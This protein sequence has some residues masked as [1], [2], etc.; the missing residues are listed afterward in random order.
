MNETLWAMLTVFGLGIAY[1]LAAIPTGVAMHLNPWTAALCAWAGYTAIAAA[2]LAVGTPARKWLT[3]KFGISARPDPQKL[4]WRVWIRWGLPGLA[5]IAPVTCGPYFAALI[6]LML[7]ERPWRLLLWIAL[8]VIPWC[9]F[10]VVLAETGSHLFQP[11][12]R[13]RRRKP[14]PKIAR[15]RAKAQPSLRLRSG[16]LSQSVHSA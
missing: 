15:A 7:G 8:G 12:N 11:G 1:F 6:A 3:E 4:L 14:D 5:L 2:M 9:I 13:P 16:L 10:F